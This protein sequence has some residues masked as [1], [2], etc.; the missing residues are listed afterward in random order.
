MRC[1][2]LGI[3][4]VLLTDEGAGVHAARALAPLLASRSDVQVIDAGTLSFTLAPL[5][6]EADRLIV[7]DAAQLNERAG[8]VRTYFD[9]AFDRFL[10]TAKLTVHEVSLVDLF[11]IA[12]LTD[13]LPAQRVL[14]AVQPD[15]I[16]WGSTLTPVVQAAV[17]SI[18][19]NVVEMLDD[20]PLPEHANLDITPIE[21][22]LS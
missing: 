9:R 4:N 6:E 11:D 18:V 22:V 19:S 7:I 10:G 2:V 14:F 3:G 8:T 13:G 15:T 16:G 12:R 17:D 20:W 1:V 5:I 21:S